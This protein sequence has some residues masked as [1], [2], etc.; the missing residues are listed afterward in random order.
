MM[1]AL[2]IRRRV[3]EMITTGEL[4][5][6]DLAGLWAG[7]GDGKRCAACAEMIGAREVEYEVNL[8]SG[9]KVLLQGCGRET[10]K[11]GGFSRR[12]EALD[13]R[14]PDSTAPMWPM[15]ER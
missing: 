2:T 4:P 7:M 13:T 8:T 15:T 3:R 9:K 11:L 14:G 6:D 10:K 1:D 12:K 5:C